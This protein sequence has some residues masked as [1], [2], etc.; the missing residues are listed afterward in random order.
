MDQLPGLWGLTCRLNPRYVNNSNHP[1]RCL[2]FG[3]SPCL[4]KRAASLWRGPRLSI[5]LGWIAY[6]SS[7]TD[8]AWIHSVNSIQTW[9]ILIAMLGL[10]V[11]PLQNGSAHEKIKAEPLIWNLFVHS[12]LWHEDTTSACK[13][14]PAEAW[15]SPP[16]ANSHLGRPSP[17]RCLLLLCSLWGNGR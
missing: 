8:E 7:V 1:V 6:I 11:A 13:C 15:T 2:N 3:M 17:P 14:R 4:G 10:A 5:S 12:G 16:L 9:F